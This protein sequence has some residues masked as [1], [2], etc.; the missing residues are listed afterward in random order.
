MVTLEKR[1][2][3]R[4]QSNPGW[5]KMLPLFNSVGARTEDSRGRLLEFAIHTPLIEKRIERK[6]HSVT[7]KFRWKGSGRNSS[8]KN[9]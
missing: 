1:L 8:K 5:N 3:K 6:G 7:Y 9:F 2:E 4:L